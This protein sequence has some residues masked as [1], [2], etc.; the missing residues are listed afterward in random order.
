[1]VLAAAVLASQ[2]APDLDS[3]TRN[4]VQAAVEHF[5]SQNVK[6]DEIG[7]A[8]AK[9]DR[10][11]GRY[12]SGHY[13]GDQEM[14]PASVVKLFF[15]GYL[16][17]LR[18]TRKIRPAP[19]LERAT[20]DM[21]VDSVNDATALVLDAITGTTGGPELPPKALASWM[22]RRQTVN[23]WYRSLGFTGVNASQKTWNEGPYGRERQGYGPNFELRNSLTPDACL[24]LM[25]EI[26][27]DRFVSPAQC[28]FMKGLL[29]RQIP[30][31]TDQPNYQATFVGK[32]LPSGTKLWSKAG[33]VDR[34]RHDVA[35]VRF[36]SGGE[37]VLA[38]FTREHS[39]LPD[40]IPY[41]AAR[42]LEQLGEKGLRM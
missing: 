14:Y 35:Y 42:A 19:E 40:L 30:A 37:Y 28:A 4:A 7:F 8:L 34:Q 10:A 13:R 9:L 41:V 16:A 32:A 23:R 1:M 15:L 27:L 17:H 11:H 25:S 33:W 2:A 24:R 21:I 39:D 29:S 6:P 31:E 5:R 18:E 20:H 36:A 3:I 12:A 22:E 26:A 38:I